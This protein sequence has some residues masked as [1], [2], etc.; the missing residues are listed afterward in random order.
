MDNIDRTK[1]PI[2][3]DDSYLGNLEVIQSG[4]GFFIGRLLLE[5]GS[6]DIDVGSRETDYFD[7][8]EEAEQALRD[9]TF[10]VRDCLENNYAYQTGRLPCPKVRKGDQHE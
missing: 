9:G 4:A 8:K 7:S 10:E 1:W 6:G 5:K 2:E 3:R